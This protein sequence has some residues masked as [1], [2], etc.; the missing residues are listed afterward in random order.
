M[1]NTMSKA[2]K[3][4]EEAQREAARRAVA[5]GAP[6]NLEGTASFEAKNSHMKFGGHYRKAFKKKLKEHE[7]K[8]RKERKEEKKRAKTGKV[9]NDPRGRVDL[10][11]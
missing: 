6:I 2:V 11:E 3:Q 9:K 10:L 5:A 7:K 8:E 4:R 1:G